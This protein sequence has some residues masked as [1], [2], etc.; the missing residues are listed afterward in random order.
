MHAMRV[1]KLE[2]VSLAIFTITITIQRICFFVLYMLLH[3]FM[4]YICMYHISQWIIYAMHQ[5]FVH[6]MSRVKPLN[7]LTMGPNFNGPFSFM[8]GLVSWII[9]VMVLLCVW[10]AHWP[11]IPGQ[12]ATIT[13]RRLPDFTHYTHTH[14][15]MWHF[16]SDQRAV[17][18]TTVLYGTQ[19]KR[20]I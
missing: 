12:W 18:T 1:V 5:M 10:L 17:Q 9:I 14:L 20:S 4:H 3:L 8:V 11:G 13:S 19:I 15:S 6:Y 7:R 2:L 16:A